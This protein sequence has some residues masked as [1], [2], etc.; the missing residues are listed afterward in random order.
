MA[1]TN[2]TSARKRVGVGISTFDLLGQLVQ[3]E[4]GARAERLHQAV[5]RQGRYVLVR[6]RVVIVNKHL[7]LLR[8]WA[9]AELKRCTGRYDYTHS[10]RRRSLTTVKEATIVSG[11]GLV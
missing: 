9:Y 1:D 7:V 11:G 10:S 2:N 3:E 5:V 6:G 8:S 4:C